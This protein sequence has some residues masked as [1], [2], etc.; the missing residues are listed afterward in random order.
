MRFYGLM[1]S[2]MGFGIGFYWTAIAWVKQIFLVQA[3]VRSEPFDI[4]THG[5]LAFVFL[6]SVWGS[7]YLYKNRLQF[8]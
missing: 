7:W 2:F 3:G 6:F 8:D 4:G 5:M 1:A